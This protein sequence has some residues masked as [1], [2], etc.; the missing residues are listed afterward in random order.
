[1]EKVYIVSAIDF[2]VEPIK[3]ITSHS[4]IHYL[5]CGV[6]SLNASK[7]SLLLAKKLARQHVI[8]IGTAGS[9]Y[10]FKKTHLVTTHKTLW[11][12]PCERVG[13]SWSIENLHPPLSISKTSLVKPLP[14]KT[15]ITSPTISKSTLIS[16]SLTKVLP[17]KNELI[18]NLELYPVLS[19]LKQYAKSIS[20][21]LG[22]TNEL[23]EHARTQWLHNHK[24]AAAL[25]AQFLGKYL[26]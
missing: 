26:S 7:N 16:P 8:F 25:T 21:I 19:C 15:V 17:N 3:K 9:Y 23:G 11:L 20:V 4:S 5:T 13:F 2:E 14:A 22:I 24:D 1:M 6:G 18:E 12:P 10:P